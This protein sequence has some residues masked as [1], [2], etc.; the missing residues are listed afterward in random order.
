MTISIQAKLLTLLSV[1]L[2]ASACVNNGINITSVANASD[3]TNKTLTNTDPD[4]SA[5]T[6]G[7]TSSMT[8]VST[9]RDFMGA[10]S[11][12]ANGNTCTITT[13]QIPNHDAGEGSKFA[14][15]IAENSASFEITR[16][17]KV[18]SSSS[19]LGMGASAIL[20]NGIK[21]ESYPAACFDVGNEPIGRENIGCSH[22]NLDHPWRYNIGAVT[23]NNF[24]F[25]VHRAHV[26]P[27]GLY[28]YHST[29]T[30][31][32]DSQCEGNAVSPVVGFAAD[33]YPVYGS[34]FKDTSGAI[35]KA[36]S[37]YQ[38][39][40][41]KRE[42]IG[43][44]TTPYKVGNVHSDNYDG[45]FIGDHEFVTGLGD[46]DECNGMTVNGQYG[47]Y[48]TESYPYV[49]ACHSGTPSRKFR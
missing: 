6:G 8:D 21:W 16:S 23:L 39:K 18:A 41:G 44:Y 38:V 43:S 30:A 26:Q 45:Q 42:K 2:L 47:Y 11:I 3:I 28:H 29:P 22:D 24:G 10:I 31:L 48:I 7:Y 13:N 9:G 17:P 4:C 36:S 32:Y 19:Q 12:S 1:G 20:L 27:G 40:S 49:L 14:T 34:C 5:Y 46:L 37:S 25:D 35:R 15:D 33:G